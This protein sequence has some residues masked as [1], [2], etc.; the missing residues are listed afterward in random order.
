M[1]LYKE[2]MNWSKSH[3]FYLDELFVTEN[4]KTEFEDFANTDG[5]IWPFKGMRNLHFIGC[6]P[7]RSCEIYFWS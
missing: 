2:W 4:V 7:K 3:H 1:N 6:D 5:P